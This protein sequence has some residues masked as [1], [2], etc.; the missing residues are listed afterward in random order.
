VRYLI[1]IIDPG[2]RVTEMNEDN[3]GRYSVITIP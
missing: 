2:N 1:G 3:Y